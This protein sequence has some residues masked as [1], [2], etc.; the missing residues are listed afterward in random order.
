MVP[1]IVVV[2][3]F[4][5]DPGS[6][7]HTALA[8]MFY[9]SD[10]YKGKRTREQF[11]QDAYKV[12]FEDLLRI[13][14]GKW[15]EH[16]MNGT[17]QVCTPEDPIVYHC[18]SQRYAG[19]IFLTPDAPPAAGTT[20]YRS[21]ASKQRRFVD[22]PSMFAGGFYDSTLWET[23]DVIGNVYNRLVLW[24]GDLVHSASCYFGQTVDNAR[25][26]QMFFFDDVVDEAST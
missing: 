12:A 10:G 13:K 3:N 26:F 7:R 16:E 19:I 11:L 9:A 1:S 23:V 25:L 4:L 22:D 21:K 15:G 20:L 17:F 5:P 8:Q 2:D 18:D 14:I 6:V 24:R